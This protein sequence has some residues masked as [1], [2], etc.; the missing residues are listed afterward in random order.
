MSPTFGAQST[1]EE[2]TAGVDLTGTTWLITGVN[3]GLG[4]ESARVLSSRGARIVGLARTRSKAAASS[5]EFRA[6]WRPP[7]T[8]FSWPIFSS[9]VMRSSRSRMR[10]DGGSTAWAPAPVERESQTRPAVRAV[11]SRFRTMAKSLI[12]FSTSVDY[13]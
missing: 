12:A 1:A 3:S 2:V 5:R 8:W 13:P 4:R 10:W 6:R 9:S 7:G 11:Q